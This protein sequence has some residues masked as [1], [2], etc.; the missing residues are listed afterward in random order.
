MHKNSQDFMIQF[1]FCAGENCGQ[2]TP[3]FQ[4]EMPSFQ[5][6]ES[7]G[8]EIRL[9]TTPKFSLFGSVCVCVSADGSWR[10]RGR[11]L[12]EELHIY[13]FT[14]LH[15]Y[16]IKLYIIA[17]HYKDDLSCTH[18]RFSSISVSF[19]LFSDGIFKLLRSL[20][21]ESKG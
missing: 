6:V 21:I 20:G 4:R 19:S 8:K 5:G 7:K 16:C 12:K 14:P 9:R 11:W 1:S 2:A 18:L 15:A 10:V 17:Q 3:Y 13:F